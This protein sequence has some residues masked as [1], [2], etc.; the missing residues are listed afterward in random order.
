MDRNMGCLISPNDLRDYRPVMAQQI[1]LPTEF[2]LPTTKIKD[3]GMVGSCVAHALS[4]V[5]EQYN[6]I[7]STG[8]IYGYRPF[9]YYQGVGMYPRE[10]LK[11]LQKW[12]AV[13]QEDFPY[14]VEMIKAKTLVDNREAALKVKA[15]PFKIQSYVRLYGENEI[16]NFLYQNKIPV[17]ICVSTENLALDEN[18][19]IYIPEKKPNMPGHMIIIIGWNET[20]FIIQNSWGENWGDHGTAILPYEH[21]INEAW[22]VVL[23]E[24]AGSYIGKKPNFYWLR[25]LIQKLI[26]FFKKK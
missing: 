12:G 20:G 26:E 19:I 21:E 5:V 3:Q 7:F 22:G 8:W 4:S 15:E 2:C 9:G 18:N 10:A 13:K 1:D 23:Y 16:K 25:N 14:N 24:E 11:T 17:P 6:H